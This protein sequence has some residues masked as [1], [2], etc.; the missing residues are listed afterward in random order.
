MSIFQED[1]TTTNIYAPNSGI[2]K[3]VKK[4]NDRIEVKN[5]TIKVIGKKIEKENRTKNW[6]DKW[7]T[8]STM[9]DLNRVILITALNDD[10]TFQW[11]RQTCKSRS[12]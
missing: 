8:S 11:G 7:K 4:D 3:Y 10:L 1:I 2:P 12:C 5:E 9:L 6:W